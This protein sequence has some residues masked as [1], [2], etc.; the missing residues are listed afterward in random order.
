MDR[1]RAIIATM[2][3]AGPLR[4]LNTI[5]MQQR[6]TLITAMEETSDKAVADSSMLEALATPTLAG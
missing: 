3:T 2:E 5:I 1:L 6:P 4:E